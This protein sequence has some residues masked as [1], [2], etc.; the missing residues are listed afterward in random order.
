MVWLTGE[1]TMGWES[2]YL[3][4]IGF[5]AYRLQWQDFV[6]LVAFCAGLFILWRVVGF[7]VG[8]VLIYAM[9]IPVMYLLMA[10]FGLGFAGGI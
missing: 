9:Y 4:P 2:G 5:G 1:R 10:F 8:L 7:T 3:R 6:L